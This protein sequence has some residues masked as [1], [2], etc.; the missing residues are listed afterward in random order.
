MYLL[1]IVSLHPV[2]NQNFNILFTNHW[3]MGTK[4][5][6][7]L[8][9]WCK[10]KY[11]YSNLTYD[12]LKYEKKIS[13]KKTFLPLINNNKI[14]TIGTIFLEWGK[15]IYFVWSFVYFFCMLLSA[16]YY[17]WIKVL[18][19]IF[20]WNILFKGYFPFYIWKIKKTKITI[21]ITQLYILKGGGMTRNPIFGGQVNCIGNLHMSSTVKFLLL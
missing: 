17:V 6:T 20:V 8:I 9:Y 15:D 16:I 4:T 3:V 11:W 19:Y 1:T 7:I 14:V 12:F 21:Y 2:K 10:K 18:I 13:T 5:K